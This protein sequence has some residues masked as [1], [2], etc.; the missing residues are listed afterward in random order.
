VDKEFQVLEQ[1]SPRFHS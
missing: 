1:G